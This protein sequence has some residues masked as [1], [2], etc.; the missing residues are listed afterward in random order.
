MQHTT[1]IAGCGD[2]GTTLGLQLQQQGHKVFGLRRNINQLPQGIQGISADLTQLAGL[3]SKLAELHSCDFLLFCC[4]AN[5]HTE[6]GYR[7]AYLEGFSNL[8]QALPIRPKH[9]FF[10]SSTAVYHQ[11]DHDWV[12]EESPCNPTGFNGKIMLEAEQQVQNLDTPATVVRFSGIYGPGRNHLLHRVQRGDTAP[13]EPP[14]FSNRIHRDDCAGVLLHLINRLIQGK[15]VDNCYLASDDQP[16]TL[17]EVTHW[18]AAEMNTPLRSE[19]LSRRTGSKRC[20]NSRLKTSGYQFI[21]PNYR[22]GY[23]KLLS[24][25]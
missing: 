6:A 4:A 5:Q 2:V 20:N 8:L 18:L 17:H 10:T 19:T 3:K 9:I 7:A 25:Q 11:N 14:L 22:D 12:D 21:Y 23:L 15:V 24:E 16:S 13:A 1:L